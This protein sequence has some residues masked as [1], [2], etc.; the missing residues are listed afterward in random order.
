MLIKI[1]LRKVLGLANL[2]K[3]RRTTQLSKILAPSPLYL[4]PI[5]K[6]IICA[7]F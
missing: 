1:T 7:K 3:V 2:N 4:V 5:S 6:I